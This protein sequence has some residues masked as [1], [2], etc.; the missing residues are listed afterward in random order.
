MTYFTHVSGK[1]V[2]LAAM[3]AGATLAQPALADDVLAEAKA[4][5]EQGYAGLYEAPP[6]TGPAAVT[7]KTIWYISCGQAFV[8]CAQQAEGFAEA[9][10]QLG[11]EI[12]I[13]DGKATPSVASDI[14]RQA[15]AAKA[16]GIAI[17]AFDCPGVKSAL[18][19]A[20]AE[21]IPV[22][23]VQ[24]ID[25]SADVFGSEEPLFTASVNML[26]S[27]DARDFY[28][29][30]G[31]LRANYVIARTEGQGKVISIAETSQQVQQ[32]NHKGFMDT[33]AKCEGCEVAESTFNFGQVPSPATQ[34][35]QSALLQNPDAVAV[36][37]GIDALMELGL[38]TA[39]RQSGRS[40]LVVGGGE[41]FPNNF[42]LIRRGTQTFSIALPFKWFGWAVADTMN[43]VQAGEDPTE[44]PNQGTGF[45]FVDAEHN[46][47]EPGEMLEPKLDF[48]A[49]YL[50]VWNG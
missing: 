27:T 25:C 2:S 10:E 16:D 44:M 33:I 40:D 43:R 5:V 4:M 18:L 28:Y 21:G 20:K 23:S 7:D 36:E 34:I 1:G 35:W 30:F 42:D 38:Q 29:R 50:S 39:V 15:V 49:A 41:G 19:Q 17:S 48:R 31:E 22:V 46:L 47:P 6:E 32:M 3:I 11:W 12:S 13:Q 24:S 26:G 14:I 8:L 45:I 9:A 37:Y